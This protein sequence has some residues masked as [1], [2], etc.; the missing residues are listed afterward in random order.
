M[1]KNEIVSVLKYALS[2][3]SNQFLAIIVS[4]FVTNMIS[5]FSPNGLMLLKFL[6]PF[7]VYL[8]LLYTS[9]WGRGSS[10]A[11]RMRLSM[12]YNNKFRGFIAGFIAALPSFVFAVLAFISE[13]G[14]ASFFEFLGVDGVT[15]INRFINIPFGNLYLFANENPA[16][17]LIFP[18]FIP[19]ISGIA[20]ILGINEISLKQILLYK[21]DSE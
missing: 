16:I 17:N 13:S 2:I 11:N 20:Y 1:K 9:S 7:V 10:D 4:F 21:A 19:M 5:F 6:I 14:R 12:L 18:F 3:L 15:A 8:V